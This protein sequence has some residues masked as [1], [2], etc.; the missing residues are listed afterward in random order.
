M[1]DSLQA[2]LIL[3]FD[4]LFKNFIELALSACT[5]NNCAAPIQIKLLNNKIDN[6]EE[7]NCQ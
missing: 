6:K 2:N 4:Y 1:N 3:I 7:T 5:M